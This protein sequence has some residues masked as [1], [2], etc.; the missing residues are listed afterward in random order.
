MNLKI[1]SRRAEIEIEAQFQICYQQRSL[2]LA[3]PWGGI[4]G[5]YSNSVVL[6]SCSWSCWELATQVARCAFLE[7][8]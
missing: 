7:A 8:C 2:V 5:W 4:I 1:K 6:S 3:V